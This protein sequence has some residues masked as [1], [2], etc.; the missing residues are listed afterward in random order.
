MFGEMD[1]FILIKHNGKKYKTKS[2][3]EAGKNPVWNQEIIL[4]IAA[5]ND[6]ILLYCF[7]EDI[8]IDDFIGLAKLNSQ[9]FISPNTADGWH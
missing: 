8:I 1:P 3:D 4:P 7:D 9:D 5:E 6:T 2:I